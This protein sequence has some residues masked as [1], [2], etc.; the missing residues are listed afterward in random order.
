MTDKHW[1]RPKP[2]TSLTSGTALVLVAI[3][4]ITVSRSFDG[5]VQGLLAGAGVALVLIGVATLSPLLRH[6]SRRTPGAGRGSTGT[7]TGAFEASDSTDRT[8]DRNAGNGKS[9][10]DDPDDPDQGWLPSRHVRP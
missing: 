2:S 1:W 4:M 9:D 8:A 3:A 6:S 5:F 7:V 10:P